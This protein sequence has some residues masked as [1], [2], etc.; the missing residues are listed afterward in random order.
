MTRS[1]RL[2]SAAALLTLASG[3]AWAQDTADAAKTEARPFGQL[4][5]NAGWLSDPKTPAADLWEA[6]GG[7]KVHLDDRLRFEYGQTDGRRPSYAV[8]NRLRL[9]YETKPFKGFSAMLEME[10]VATPDVDLYWVPATGD[11]Q[12]NR[13]VIADPP[14]T[15]VN[16]AWLR[17]NNKDLFGGEGFIDLKAGRQRLTFD[18]HRFIGNVGWRQF[19]QTLDAAR[20]DVGKGR[21]TL[22]YA[23]VWGVQ[24]IFSEGAPNWDG[25]TH[26]IHASFKAHDALVI[27]PFAYL[28]RFSNAAANSS[29]NFGVRLTGTIPL[30]ASGAPKLA[31]EATYAHQSD[32]FNNPTSYDADF[33]AVDAGVA[34]AGHGSIGAGYQFLG[35]DNGAAAFQF[36]LGTNHKFNGWADLFLTTPANGLQDFYIYGKADLPW[37]L[38]GEVAYHEFWFDEG[39]T[40]IGYEIDAVISRKISNNWVVLTKLANFDGDAGFRDTVRFWLE[41]TF[42]F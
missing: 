5:P 38:K 28:Y 16:Q 17:Y 24:R 18:D 2:V 40:N 27:T 19:E 6:I 32:A 12:S 30:G 31:Y 1:A 33:F 39:G 7:G 3:M 20:I 14:D 34:F 42:S 11:G 22:T 29:D 10:N 13:T 36:P 4:P 15:E 26:L 21:L 41:T 8:T 35:S 23:Y 25:D 9:G 37:K